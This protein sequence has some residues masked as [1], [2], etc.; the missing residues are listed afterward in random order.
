MNPPRFASRPPFGARQYRRYRGRWGARGQRRTPSSS[1]AAAAVSPRPRSG[2]GRRRPRRRVRVRAH[3][4]PTA[5]PKPCLPSP[6]AR[7]LRPLPASRFPDRIPALLHALPTLGHVLGRQQST[8]GEIL[9]QLRPVETDT[10]ANES[11]V[12]KSIRAGVA[13]QSRPSAS[14]VRAW[15]FLLG[16]GSDLPKD[17][18]SRGGS[19]MQALLLRRRPRRRGASSR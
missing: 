2:R 18:S 5:C 16:A 9:V 6:G 11:P 15:V 10:A 8:H 13:Q 1:A 7:A 14:F 12:A 19:T 4:R 3:R 17:A